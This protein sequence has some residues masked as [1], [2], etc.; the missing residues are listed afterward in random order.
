MHKSY[1][2]SLIS[3]FVSVLAQL[4]FVCV[5]RVLLL[6]KRQLIRTSLHR[7]LELSLLRENR[8]LLRLQLNWK[9]KLCL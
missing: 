3:C 7:E 6:W 4:P 1:A 2:Y 5:L 9:N 8:V